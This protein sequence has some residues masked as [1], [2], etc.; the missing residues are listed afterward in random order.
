MP[1]R[2]LFV[3]SG[4]LGQRT[5]ADGVRHAF[6]AERG[7]VHVTQVLLTDDLTVQER[8]IR[9]L[10][11]M[12]VLPAVPGLR[13]LDLHRFRCEVNAGLLA[14]NRIR[15]LERA[16]SRFD[17]LHFHR[18]GTAYASLRRM[19]QTPSIVSIDSTQR[20]RLQTASTRVEVRSYAAN[21]E[22]DGRIF[23]AARLIIAASEWARRSVREEYPECATDIEVMPPPIRLLPR[24]AGWAHERFARCSAA[25]AKPRFLFVG[26]DFPRKGGFDLLEAWRAGRFADRASLDIMTDWPLP[27]GVPDGVRLHRNVTFQSPAWLE[28]WRSADVFVLPTCD[29]A[30]GLVFQEA[31]AAALPAIGTDLNAVPEIIQDGVTG[32]LI[33]PGDRRGLTAAMDALAASPERRREMGERARAW[34]SSSAD[35]D[36]YWDR[37]AAAIR[38]LAG[39]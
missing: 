22:R 6:A 39:H 35:A 19:R 37:L 16:G 25:D 4:I 26:G 17:V 2:A 31:G 5:F 1:T 30:F 11:C 27:T 32:L 20:A 24:A 15:R 21:V 23:R 29:E 3:N 34:I 14:R 18:Q 38:R 33:R 9:K 10:L 12:R 13:N 8:V 7:G 28:L 36:R